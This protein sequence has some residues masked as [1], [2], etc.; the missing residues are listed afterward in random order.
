MKLS[1]RR[2]VPADKEARELISPKTV[3]RLGE[4]NPRD[5]HRPIVAPLHARC[6]L[7]MFA[8]IRP[9]ARS[10]TRAARRLRCARKPALAPI[11]AV[12]GAAD[13]VS[14]SPDKSAQGSYENGATPGVSAHARRGALGWATVRFAE[15]FR[16]WRTIRGSTC[17]ARKTQRSNRRRHAAWYRRSRPSAGARAERVQSL[18]C[19][20]SRTGARGAQLQAPFCRSAAT[21]AAAAA[22][23]KASGATLRSLHGPVTH[24]AC[25]CRK[26]ASVDTDGRVYMA[27][28]IAS[29]QS[30]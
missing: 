23:E 10:G 28:P 14:P 25:A 20:A 5:G 6:R 2:R 9:T 19:A 16:G 1:A 8:W 12:A 30:P 11:G 18:R 22:C 4:C 13:P 27:I 21:S 7:L 29:R 15:G 17:C 26:T 24:A 3:D